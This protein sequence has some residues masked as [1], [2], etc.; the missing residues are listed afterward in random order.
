MSGPG[1]ETPA[2]PP[3]APP[4]TPPGQPAKPSGGGSTSQATTA[5]SNAVSI[6]RQRLVAGEQMVLAAASVIV[7]I[8]YL[9]F[10]FLLDYPIVSDFTVV[11]AVLTILAI[12]IHRWGHYDFGKGYRIVVGALGLSLALFAVINLLAWVRVGGGSGD[13]L[14][15]I[16]RIIFWVSGLAAGYGAWMVFRIRED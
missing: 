8:V 15:L 14:H 16:G 3:T 1:N 5:V 7:L 2:T 4:A 12:W 10:Q 11:M 9:L 6:V 13:F